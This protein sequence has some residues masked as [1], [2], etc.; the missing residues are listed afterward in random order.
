VP[1]PGEAGRPLDERLDTAILQATVRLLK[2]QGYARMSIAG[3]AEE[4]GVGRPAIYRRYKDK[5]DLVSSAIAFMR[6]RVPAPDTGSTR[7]DLLQ[8][9]EQARR[10][11][12]MSLAGTLLVEQDLHPELLDRFRQRMLHP[13]RE[14]VAAALQRGKDRGEVRADL[15]LDIAAQLLMGP[16]LYHALVAGRPPRGWAAAVLDQLWPAF[17]A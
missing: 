8:H 2:E 4:A 6:T 13:H 10:L 9:L 3:V 15:D 17:A 7:D 11:Y 12:D 14:Q 1:A 16:F 5:A